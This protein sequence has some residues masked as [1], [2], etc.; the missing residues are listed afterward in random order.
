MKP[1]FLLFAGILL[2]TAS[3]SPT[4]KSQSGKSSASSAFYADSSTSSILVTKGKDN[5]GDQ[6][7]I[8][9]TSYKV[10][11]A[12]LPN[13]DSHSGNCLVRL[14]TITDKNTGVEGQDRT[15]LFR[16]CSLNK[17]NQ[18]L[19]SG[20]HAC[21]D[22]HFNWNNFQTIKYGCCGNPDHIQLYDYQDQ[23]IIEGTDQPIVAS[24]PNHFDFYITYQ[25]KNLQDSTLIGT[26]HLSYNSHDT[27][28]IQLKSK[29]PVS[30]MD[31]PVLSTVY[32]SLRS[33]NKRDQ[34]NSNENQYD[35]WSQET[36]TLPQQLN[37][38]SIRIHFS[39]DTTFPI[40]DIPIQQGKPFGKSERQ[41]VYW[42][43][44]N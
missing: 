25:D 34:Y 4:T 2:L 35:L 37:D 39:C 44:A 24:I 20:T 19:L 26:I 14:Q 33:G 30:E 5:Y 36:C 11:S 7:H 13:Q 41:Q 42:V 29:R 18:V 28:H 8:I 9:E 38:L 16:I 10:I 40:I 31:C 32:V 6:L 21:D 43:K 15:I 17:P 23:L 1:V 12:H 22:I 3:C 27:Y